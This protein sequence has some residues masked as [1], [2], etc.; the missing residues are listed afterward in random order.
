MPLNAYLISSLL[1]FSELFHDDQLIQNHCQTSFSSCIDVSLCLSSVF[2]LLVSPSFSTVVTTTP[3]P[4]NNYP[5]MP[6]LLLLPQPTPNKGILE[7]PDKVSSLTVTYHHHV[8]V[9][10]GLVCHALECFTPT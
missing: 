7:K 1:P 5:L 6:L 4:P 3:N 10:F 2:P 9:D 8:S